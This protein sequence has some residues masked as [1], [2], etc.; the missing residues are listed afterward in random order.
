MAISQMRQLSL[1]LPKELLDRLLFYLQGLESV[2]IHDLR[3]EEDWP[4][5]FEKALVGRPVQ[6]LSQQDLVSRQE[7]LERLVEELEPFMPKKKLL[8][9][10]KEEPLE[11]SFAALEQA[12]K[13]RDEA[14]LLEGISKQL[15]VLQEAKSQIE[16]DRLEVAELEK[17]EPLELTP[18]AAA[19]FSHLGALIGTIPNTDD[20]ALRLALGAHADLKFQEVFTDDTEHG[21]LIFYKTGS[22][23]EVRRILKEYGFK[24]FEYDHAE[25]PADRLE[26]LKSNIRQQE[27]VVDAMTK[28]LA[29]SKGEL[30]QLKVQLDYLC[31]LSS[32]Q[33]SKNQ[34]ASTQNLAALEG[35]IESNQVQALEACLTEQFGQSILIQ[36]REIRQDEKDK[37]PTKLKNNALVE[38]FELVTEMYSL[39]KYG[40]K[41]PTPVVS[42]FYFV[43]FGM[44]VA[45][46]GYGLLLFAGT[47]LALRFLHVKPGMAKNLRFFRL[48]GVAVI[49]WGLVYGSFFGFELPFALISTSSDAMTIL[50]ISVVFGFITVLAGLFLSGLKNIR[51]KD[52]AE[53]YNA[54][55]AWVLILLGLLLLALGNFFPSLAFAATIGQ[56]LAIINALGVLAVSIISA[57][58]LAGLGS[59]LFNLY[60]VSGYVGD[61]VSFTRLMALGLSGASIGSAFNLIVSLFPPVARFSIGILL[62]IALHLV[63]MFLSFLSG[64]VH[65]AR[66]I[67]VEFFGKFYDG[68]GKPFTPLKPSE[69]YVQQSKK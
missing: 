60:N 51:L 68:G 66:L 21:V 44:M 40:D 34:L 23:E 47:S 48:L 33:E 43:F 14:V 38:P 24:P 56:W 25:L 9:S 41:D 10:L 13:N 12:G 4:A 39:P 69:K 22:L 17:W 57:K 36:T 53:A 62:F 15:K 8:E 32:R 29:A 50:V 5:A 67:F 46:I 3:Q 28:S 20:D 52:Y 37:V 16:A 27:A 59:G 58:S 35:W 2:Q 18:Q 19:T 31:N 42:L 55:F 26:Q 6:Q 7:K 30:D 45:D 49:I 1:L 61:L 65:G 64:Y 63:N 54:G 11:L